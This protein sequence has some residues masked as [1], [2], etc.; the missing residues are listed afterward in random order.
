VVDDA[1]GGVGVRDDDDEADNFSSEK[2]AA[3]VDDSVLHNV[4]DFHRQH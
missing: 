1:V 3:F 2:R 4:S